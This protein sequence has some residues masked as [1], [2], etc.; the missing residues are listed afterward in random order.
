MFI[1]TG[2]IKKKSLCIK[3]ALNV[4][5]PLCVNEERAEYHVQA[6]YVLEILS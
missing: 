5:P 2:Q 6:Q 3:P 1:L 4:T